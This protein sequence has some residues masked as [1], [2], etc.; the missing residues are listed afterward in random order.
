MGGELDRV[1]GA[2][3]DARKVRGLTQAQAAGL[4]GHTQKWLS[5]FERG[6][7]DPP[8]SMVLRLLTL[9]GLRLDLTPTVPTGPPPAD[10]RDVDEGL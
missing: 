10:E 5:D 3:R 7:T 9:L 4:I 2:V 6:R 1:R 8:A